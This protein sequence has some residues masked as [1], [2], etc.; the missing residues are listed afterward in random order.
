MLEAMAL[1]ESAQCEDGLPARVSPAHAGAFHALRRQ[2][3]ACC[4]DDARADGQ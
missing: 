2:S 4:F 1:Y 3:L